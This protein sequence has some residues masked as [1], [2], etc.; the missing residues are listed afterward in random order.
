MRYQNSSEI[1]RP[2]GLAERLATRKPKLQPRQ[3]GQAPS[4]ILQ[5]MIL[6]SNLKSKRD[7]NVPGEEEGIQRKR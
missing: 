4:E 5:L 7:G 2:K 3:Y 1:T 6:L